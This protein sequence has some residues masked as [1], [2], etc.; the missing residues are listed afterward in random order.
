MKKVDDTS[1]IQSTTFNKSDF[2]AENDVNCNPNPSSSL[3][4]TACQA[5]SSEDN[6]DPEYARKVIVLGPEVSSV[7]QNSEIKLPETIQNTISGPTVP[8]TSSILNTTTKAVVPNTISST[9]NIKPI[10]T[11]LQNNYGSSPS[12]SVHQ[13]RQQQQTSEKTSVTTTPR[14]STRRL[15]VSN[16]PFRFREADLR[17]LLGPFGPILDVEIIFNER[18]SKGF[19][20]V[21]FMNA[22]DAEKARENLNGHV[23]MG[24][25]IEVNHAT[26]RVLTKKRTD[27][28]ISAGGNK[29]SNFNNQNIGLNNYTSTLASRPRITGTS[30]GTSN[31]VVA[32]AISAA[33]AVAAMSGS[34]IVN[35]HTLNGLCHLPSLH[36]SNLSGN[37]LI[38]NQN[39]SSL[40]PLTSST[41]STVTSTSIPSLSSSVSSS[42]SAALVN[43]LK[44]Q[45]QQQNLAAAAT[46]VALQQHN[47]L[48]GTNSQNTQALLAALMLQNLNTPNQLIKQSL[49]SLSFPLENVVSNL[50]IQTQP[51]QSQTTMF[52]SSNSNNSNNN[53]N[54]ATNNI[55]TNSPGL[56]PLTILGIN[57][58]SMNQSNIGSDLLLNPQHIRS[59]Q[60]LKQTLGNVNPIIPNNLSLATA[61]FLASNLN[62]PT[63]QIALPLI[64]HSNNGQNLNLFTSSSSPSSSTP[65]S[66]GSSIQLGTNLDLNSNE[67]KLWLASLIGNSNSCIQSDLGIA[68]NNLTNQIYQMYKSNAN[69]NDTTNTTTTNNNNNNNN[70]NT[71]L[72]V[73]SLSKTQ[74]NINENKTSSSNTLT[75]TTNTG[76]S[77]IHDNRNKNNEHTLTQSLSNSINTTKSSV[78]NLTN[79]FSTPG[80]TLTDANNLVNVAVSSLNP[81]NFGLTPL[82][83]I[84]YNLNSYLNGTA[85]GV[86][87]D[88]FNSVPIQQQTSSLSN[89][90]ALSGFGSANCFWPIIPSVSNLT[91]PAPSLT[92]PLVIGS[93]NLYRNSATTIPR[94]STY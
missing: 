57:N 84:P 20:F 3:K 24:R 28:A 17:S 25:K 29:A 34:G 86:L 35:N 22:A 93:Q 7:Q 92:T 11:N 51:Q 67:T 41:I 87:T 10:G 32:A 76:I 89:N 52:N 69:L 50:P 73:N 91:V 56:N 15:H 77:Q 2:P 36:S 45:H 66:I 64:N 42:S 78:S 79:V 75:D 19:G 31:S 48:N 80:N 70:S 54:Y 18:G 49:S 16:I 40:S 37:N 47:Q 81:F 58:P 4:R 55:G 90:S 72:K 26:T 9:N 30:V 27:N 74:L 46:A 62:F 94:F 44:A 65:T 39:K 59:Y 83:A 5:G 38:L 23:V 71:L 82:T 63:P 68:N 33:A 12:V 60:M 14:T 43:L 1:V 88:L 8:S 6:D 13:S 85:A 21:T 61:P 53:V